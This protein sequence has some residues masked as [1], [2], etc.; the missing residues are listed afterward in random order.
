MGLPF[1]CLSPC[2]PLQMVVDLQWSRSS[3]R[4]L[5]TVAQVCNVQVWANKAAVCNAQYFSGCMRV[6]S[7]LGGG[8]LQIPDCT[9]PNSIED[10][11]DAFNSEPLSVL[12]SFLSRWVGTCNSC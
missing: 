12:F 6:G 5:D 9:A 11:G 3:S 7:D 10:K 8:R 1:F 2:R 4:S